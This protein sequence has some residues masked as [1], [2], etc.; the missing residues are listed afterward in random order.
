MAGLLLNRFGG[1]VVIIT[2]ASSGLGLATAR[3]FAS[4]GAS[5]VMAARDPDR[6]H[7][8]ATGLLQAT[9]GR[10]LAVPCDI[11]NREDVG[12]LVRT[13]IGRFGRIDVLVNNAGIGMIAPFESVQIEDAITLFK[14]NFFGALNCAQA[15]LPQMRHQRKG[16]IVNV[17]SVGGLRGV[18]NISIYSASKAALIAMSDALRLEVKPFGI[19]VTVI[20]AGR[21]SETAFFDRAKSYGAVELYQVL[22]TLSP[23][24]VAD[25]LLDA[26]ATRRRMVILPFHARLLNI[27]NKLSPSLMDNFLFKR[28]PKLK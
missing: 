20:C 8:A 27:A 15:V 14:T 5:V 9:D 24:T 6:L 1:Q 13:V 19:N 2:G 11:T 18:P 22:H 10:I 12:R 3:C 21:I 28:M 4:Q 17:A 23:Q 26:V 7:C 25:A 16:Y